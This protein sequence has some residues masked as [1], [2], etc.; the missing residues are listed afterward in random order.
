VLA[1]AVVMLLI[2][3]AGAGWWF[4]VRVPVHDLPDLTGIQLEE[5]AAMAAELGYEVDDETVDRRD[6]T[7]PGE[8]L[9]QDPPP[10]EPLAE[11]ETVRLTV[12]LGATLTPL[13]DVA[14]RPEAEARATL[15]GAG[16]PIGEVTPEHH[17]EIPEGSVI[18]TALPEGVSPEADGQVPKGTRVALVVSAGPAPR[19]VP[20]G[21]DGASRADAEA[22]IAAVQLSADVSEEH[23]ETVPAGIVIR[24]GPAAGS[25]IARGGAV[26]LVVSKGPAP[27]PVPDVKW[28]SGAMAAERLE[29]DGFVVA[30]IEGSPSGMVLAT[31]PVAGELHQRGTEVRLFT[32][33]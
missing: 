6:G 30:G 9:D 17:E 25:E 15:E 16:L 22:A 19:A 23:S 7:T 12:S 18:S 31:D 26:E 27:I 20:E 28:I 11:G 2:A 10:G 5:A 8:I 4:Y 13:P 14:T 1:V 29:A 24:S 21:L 32:R 33:S 3:A